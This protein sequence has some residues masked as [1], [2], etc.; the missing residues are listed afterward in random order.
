VEL[1]A[2][3]TGVVASRQLLDAGVS[4][5]TQ[6]RIVQRGELE[7]LER[8]IL[9]LPSWPDSWHQ[10]VWRTWL[11]AGEDAVVSQMCRPTNWR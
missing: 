10:H 8:G 11:R 4:R 9:R 6:T 5:R 3:Q 1:A 2:R 7:R